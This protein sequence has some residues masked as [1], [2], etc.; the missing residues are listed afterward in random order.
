MLAFQAATFTPVAT[1]HRHMYPNIQHPD[2]DTGPAHALV[3]AALRRHPK[4]DDPEGL[5]G[6]AAEGSKAP[7]LH[8]GD[9][10]LFLGQAH[11][12]CVA[13]VIPPPIAG[14]GRKVIDLSSLHLRD[15]QGSLKA[16][17]VPLARESPSR[18]HMTVP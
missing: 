6:R 12:G 10:A 15:Q 1:L 9:K 5:A 13:T 14:R 18:A 2:R 17:L 11:Y 4:G 3:Q 7:S 8:E 16:T